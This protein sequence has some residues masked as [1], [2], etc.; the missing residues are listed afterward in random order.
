MAVNPPAGNPDDAELLNEV[1]M[2]ELGGRVWPLRLDLATM[3]RFEKATGVNMLINSAVLF[4]RNLSMTACQALLWAAMSQYV[5]QDDPMNS[6]RTGPE[7]LGRMIRPADLERVA[8]AIH[9]MLHKGLPDPEP[10]EPSANGQKKMEVTTEN[11]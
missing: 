4:P 5:E 6:P 9:D 10:V 3:S 11:P 8:D 7:V 2:F 1:T